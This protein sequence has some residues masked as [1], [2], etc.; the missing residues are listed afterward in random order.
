MS[1]KDHSNSDGSPADADALANTDVEP[2]AGGSAPRVVDAA[3]LPA[4]ADV[5]VAIVPAAG[6][7]FGRFELIS[8][9]GSGGFGE[10]WIAAKFGPHLP[11]DLRDL[12]SVG[13]AGARKV[14]I[15]R[16]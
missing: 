9:L 16:Q 4:A 14:G 1:I 6:R 15:A 8:L 7:K 2:N 13:Q 10:V 5:P 11:G 12:E 3:Q